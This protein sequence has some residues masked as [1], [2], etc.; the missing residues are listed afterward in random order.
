MR[1]RCCSS[2]TTPL[3]ALGLGI[4]ASA[5]MIAFGLWWLRHAA[6]VARRRSEGYGRGSTVT[7]DD[8]VAAETV[9]QRATTAREFDPPEVRHGRPG[10]VVPPIVLAGLPLLVVGSVNVLM[11]LAVLPRLDVSFLAEER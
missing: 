6:A 7:V 5:I 8:A 10:R 2:G 11:T 9:R 3:A 1:S 4:I